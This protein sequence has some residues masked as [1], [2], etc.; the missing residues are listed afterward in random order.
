M[1]LGDGALASR[2]FWGRSVPK[3]G[4]VAS[5]VTLVVWLCLLPVLMV[6]MPKFGGATTSS[7]EAPSGTPSARASALQHQYFDA[8]MHSSSLVVVVEALGEDNVTAAPIR[9]L[10]GRISED[11]TAE[12]AE[13]Y[14]ELKV[15]AVA[16]VF[17][18]GAAGSEFL[19]S[20]G[21]ATVILINI[22]DSKTAP[23]AT[24]KD[25]IDYVDKA[26]NDDVDAHHDDLKNYYIGLTGALPID[27][28]AGAG[29]MKSTESV[30]MFTFPIAFLVLA[31]FIRSA[32]LMI[33]PVLTIVLCIMTTYSI[34]YG[35]AQAL[36]VST[37]APALM[38]AAILA[39]N[40][41]YNLFLLT[42]FQENKKPITT[43]N[44]SLRLVSLDCEFRKG[45]TIV[46]RVV[47]GSDVGHHGIREG[48]EIAAVN[49][50]VVTSPEH[51]EELLDD[52]SAKPV[53]IQ[54]RMSLWDNVVGSVLRHTASET[55]FLSGTLVT[56]AFLSMALIPL[57]ALYG[58]G[59]CGGVAVFVCVVVNCTVT[60]A[61]LLVFG[62][63][64]SGPACCCCCCPGGV[65]RLLSCQCFGK[66][67]DADE[68]EDEEARLLKAGPAYTRSL[69]YRLA[70]KIEGKWAWVW[71][72]VVVALGAA[73]W[74][75]FPDN[76]NHTKINADPLEFAPRTDESVKA[77]RR[78]GAHF[79]QGKFQAY[80]LLLHNV[81]ITD[82]DGTGANATF[83]DEGIFTPEGYAAMYDMVHTV[84]NKTGMPMRTFYGPVSIP[85]ALPAA[86]CNAAAILECGA[87]YT[88]VNFN[89]APKETWAH[90]FALL[91][92]FLAMSAQEV[93]QTCTIEYKQPME[94]CIAAA[95][96][97]D[98]YKGMLKA[99]VSQPHHA[100][101]YMQV[102]TPF[103][104]T[105][106]DAMEWMD[107]LAPVMED[108]SAAH[109]AVEYALTGGNAMFYDFNKKVN[110][111]MPRMIG[112]LLAAVFVIVCVVFRSVAI[113]A[114][115]GL[116]IV[117]SVGSAFGLTY[118]I[119]QTTAFHWLFPF[120]SDFHQ[121]GLNWSAVPMCFAIT[122]AL[123]MD[124][125]VFIL[126]RIYEFKRRGMSTPESVKAAMGEV[127][128]TIAGAGC[129]MAI[130]FGGLM[131]T[132]V[133]V[134]NQFGVL[135]TFS[136]LID[137][138]LMTPIVVPAAL[139]TLGRFSWFPGATYRTEGAASLQP[140]VL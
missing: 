29:T 68:D 97:Q 136:I 85:T 101:G 36:N 98:V 23:T 48:Y 105:G 119:Y 115:M 1:G 18:A 19:S 34:C 127:S 134:L 113:G 33:I 81:S 89:A 6:L 55:V 5:L 56:I 92:Q 2:W 76:L 139:M 71:I 9:A 117:F 12:A 123:A 112:I 88:A 77:W 132:T 20:D 61:L 74:V 45:S 22:G 39:F 70:A 21:K 109:P 86:L 40:V 27:F 82:P 80:Q 96:L 104:P 43:R 111:D 51:L 41:D 10:A 137:T 102:F 25:F 121:Q 78:M 14:A 106:L 107:R 32:R 42:R 95:A 135:L 79:D 57:D 110:E 50:V 44:L 17:S 15:G 72:V 37:I 75:R 53:V 138:F 28:A 83:T 30:E 52:A 133:V 58:L 69:W 94:V 140:S 103:Q 49:G 24:L 62:P 63:F 11:V 131:L 7:F 118:Y 90:D 87:D 66:K 73:L 124:Y 60:P 13:K 108:W 84:S 3:H 4:R 91:Q 128:G 99:Q 129:I 116:T 93:I 26:V 38:M 126:T 67:Q 59:V 125:D 114:I 8:F 120:L 122:V 100:A 130:A 54:W 31:C 64:F 47:E 35:V 46:E 65:E 16:S